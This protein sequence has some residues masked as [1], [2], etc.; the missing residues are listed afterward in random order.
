MSAV[1]V[2]HDW[3]RS[4][5]APDPLPLYWEEG[6]EEKLGIV[7]DALQLG[8]SE[9]VLDL[10]C[11]TGLR[12][13]ELCRRGFQVIGVDVCEELLSIAGGGAELLGIYPYFVQVDPREIL[14]EDEFDLIL[15]MGGGAFGHFET[16]EDDLEA[17]AAAA[18][19]LRSG[20]RLVVQAP[21]V[22]HVEEHLPARTWLVE[23]EGD[24]DES[25]RLVE[26]EWNDVDRRIE[27]TIRAI[28]PGEAIDDSEPV[29]FQRRLYTLEEMAGVFEHVG[30]GLA[31]VFDE[32]GDRCAPTDVEQELF[33]EARKP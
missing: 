18:R 6:A 14:F 33:V 27:G 21:N 5:F 16:D 12:V 19:A 13:A 30:L 10:A 11:A 15:S 20:G 4:S 7:L 8:G 1:K 31:D 9:R 2:P 3:Y 25:L 22:R 32:D 26:Q 28:L 29:P 24:A 23:L 17:F